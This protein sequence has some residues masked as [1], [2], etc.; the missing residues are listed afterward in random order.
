MIS[1]TVVVMLAM[2][3]EI[4]GHCA[5]QYEQLLLKYSE[6]SQWIQSFFL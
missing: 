3:V 4:V 6:A 2:V 1:G 5:E